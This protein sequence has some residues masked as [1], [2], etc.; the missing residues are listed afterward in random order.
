MVYEGGCKWD[1]L[2]DADDDDGCDGDGGG[3]GGPAVLLPWPMLM[4]FIVSAPITPGVF[5]N[6]ELFLLLIYEILY[7]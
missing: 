6:L 5:F 4:M 7:V 2:T 1:P 3:G